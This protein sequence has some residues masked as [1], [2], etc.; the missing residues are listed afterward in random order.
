MRH[1][2]LITFCFLSVFLVEPEASGGQKSAKSIGRV[3]T[4]KGAVTAKGKPLAV[5]DPVYLTDVIE[6]KENSSAK[7]LL[8]DKTV[9]DIAP[10]TSFHISDF[11]LNSVADREVDGTV[12]FGEI[13]SLVSKKLNQKGRFNIR[14][15]SS[16]LAVRGTEFFVRDGKI[17]V[18][19]GKVWIQSTQGKGAGSQAMITPGQQWRVTGS[20][21]GKR[22]MEVV[23]VPKN[24][25]N[26]LTTSR[27]VR[28]NTFARTVTFGTPE[29]RNEGSNAGSK[30]DSSN[31][32]SKNKDKK[33]GSGFTVG[34][35]TMDTIQDTVDKGILADKRTGG[36]VGN[37]DSSVV[38]VPGLSRDPVDTV[39]KINGNDPL[40]QIINVKVKV[41]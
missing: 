8:S 11:K 25:L 12:D 5:G 6:T 36:G 20:D 38:E 26:Q 39:R 13:R 24:E 41:N 35:G 14:T 34:G 4:V 18:T 27:R 9:V 1:S 3:V 16:V 2:I 22:S 31:G 7:L 21:G 15:K 23:T 37:I 32:L 40:N 30:K 33:D 19:E 28:D 17:T 29:N 10:S